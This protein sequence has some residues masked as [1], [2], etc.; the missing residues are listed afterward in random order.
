LRY[1]ETAPYLCIPKQGHYLRRSG[2]IGRHARFRG[3]C[4]HGHASS[5]LAFGT[6]REPVNQAFTGSIF[7]IAAIMAKKW[8]NKVAKTHVDTTTRYQ[9]KEPVL[10]KPPDDNLA[11]QWV[12]VYGVWSESKEKLVRK[13]VTI[14]GDTVAKRLANAKATI[15]E[16]KVMLKAGVC[17]DPLPE[18]PKPAAVDHNAVTLQTPLRKAIEVY[19]AYKQKTTKKNSY[20][21]YKSSLSVLERFLKETP[22][23]KNVAIGRFHAGNAQDFLDKVVLSYNHSNRGH[24]N[25]RDNAQAVFL[26][27]A[28]RINRP[29]VTHLLANPFEGIIDK[30][31]ISKKH[32][33]FT[34]QQRTEFITKCQEMGE[35]QLLL[36]VKFMFYTFFRPREELRNIRISDIREHTIR[37]DGNMSKDNAEEYVE[38][39]PP[40]EKLIQELNLRSYPSNYY[41]FSHAGVPGPERFGKD[42]FYHHHR[43]VLA[44]LD[45][46]GE[47]DTYSWKHTGV[48][49]LWRATENIR[50]VQQHCRHSTATMT[51]D[52]LRDLGIIVRHTQIQDF[53]T[54]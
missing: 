26:H 23:M 10:S 41:V 21:T 8:Q 27:W 49:A 54:F 3:V 9:Y 19:L 7:L 32:T 34:D 45:W 25:A 13:R 39:A 24:N 22:G 6:L 28:K 53:P 43:R 16:L 50:L 2:E 46:Q 51:E 20:R 52:Y 37:V 14:T 29:G 17:V 18:E 12:V 1:C 36:F 44:R 48:I 31:T 11:K 38:I 30:V 15:S 47:Y 40:L 33:A 35:H 42:Y 4:L 5:S